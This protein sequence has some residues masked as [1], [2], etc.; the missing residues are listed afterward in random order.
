[1]QL[2]DIATL[3]NLTGIL[4]VLFMSVVM[5]RR[6]PTPFFR[7]WTSGYAC[8]F[9]MLAIDLM[10]SLL[11]RSIPLIALE[12]ALA[13]ATAACFRRVA[14]ELRGGQLKATAIATTA[15]LGGL[16]A[17]ALALAGLPYVL[18]TLPFVAA[19]LL[20]EVSLGWM[21][22]REGVDGT[23]APWLGIPFILLAV[24]TMSYPFIHATP[25]FWLGYWLTGLFNLLVGFGM[26]LYL[27]DVALGR[28]RSQHAQLLRLDQLKRSFLST[29]SHELRT[30][31][32]GMVGNL[33]F[34]EDEIGGPLTP[35]QQTFLHEVQ[36]GASQLSELVD[37]L[38]D[39]AQMESGALKVKQEAV[40]LHPLLSQARQAMQAIAIQKGLSLELSVLESLP[41]VWGDATRISQ[42]LNNLLSNAVK[43]TPEGGS[44]RIT[45]AGIPDGVQISVSDSGIGIPA[46][47]LPS[48]FDSFFQV[49]SS[50]T[51]EHR[52][53]GLGLPIVK[54]LVEA[55]GG[56]ITV[57]STPGKGSTF[58]FTL[59]LA[60]EAPVPVS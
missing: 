32:T 29:V 27:L 22:A 60:S 12:A 51:R 38:L 9:A 30:P 43:F 20:Q 58:T 14:R 4:V 52:G 11:G 39:T 50:L 8:M 23:P 33:E 7:S 42:I 3:F 36:R 24:T 1:M 31:L 41:Q 28:L 54:N 18:L 49:D 44:V 37:S 40:E 19:I 21:F 35:V 48:V 26:A 25:Y 6:H 46:A 15:G 55:M 45:S 16:M 57:E 53:S 59:P 2:T 13:L 17:A 34:L 5:L 56:A 10:A 47:A